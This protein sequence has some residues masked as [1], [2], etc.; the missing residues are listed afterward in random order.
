MG[1]KGKALAGKKVMTAI[2]SGGKR[3]VYQGGR[4]QEILHQAITGSL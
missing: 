1:G 2:S 3:E 4:T